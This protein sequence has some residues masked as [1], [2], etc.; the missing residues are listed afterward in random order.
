MLF[1]SI[2]NNYRI[3]IQVKLSHVDIHNAGWRLEPILQENRDV[4]EEIRIRGFS[5]HKLDERRVD[6][7]QPGIVRI[8]S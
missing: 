5:V 3:C 2:V 1:G 4:P 8:T 7:S 6:V